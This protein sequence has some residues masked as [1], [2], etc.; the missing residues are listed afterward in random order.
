[1]DLPT[2]RTSSRT[3]FEHENL[4]LGCGIWSVATCRREERL[5]LPAILDSAPKRMTCAIRLWVWP[6]SP[7]A[8]CCCGLLSHT[9][10][11]HDCFSGSGEHHPA[12]SHDWRLLRGRRRDRSHISGDYVKAAP[13]TFAPALR[14]TVRPPRTRGLRPVSMTRSPEPT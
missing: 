14:T 4:R 2:R 12:V 5:G 7:F 11:G 6:S 13:P 3:R 1:M 10:I 8:L 9:C